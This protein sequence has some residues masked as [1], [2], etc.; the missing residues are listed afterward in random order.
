MITFEEFVKKG[1]EMCPDLWRAFYPRVYEHTGGYGS[2]KLPAIT[3][4]STVLSPM[5]SHGNKAVYMQACMLQKQD[6]PTYFIT[7]DLLFALAQTDLPDDYDLN[8]FS[9]RW[10]AVLFMLPRD[11]NKDKAGDDYPYLLLS[12]QKDAEQFQLKLPSGRHCPSVTVVKG[13]I[14]VSTSS[15]VNKDGL[16][17]GSYNYTVIP[18]I[19]NLLGEALKADESDNNRKDREDWERRQKERPLTEKEVDVF[20]TM[21]MSELEHDFS[22]ACLKL[23][24]KI[25]LFMDS[26]KDLVEMGTPKKIFHGRDQRTDIWWPNIV[27][28]SYKIRYVYDHSGEDV[29]EHEKRNVRFHWRRGHMRRQRY[30]EGRAMVKT[31]LI[32]GLF[33]GS[34]QGEPQS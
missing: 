17:I 5:E 1:A 28:K 22:K 24:L 31:I 19:Q 27:G 33:V 21:P 29:P 20:K 18:S 14:M 30:G 23:A 4:L 2:C 15:Y 3:L 11:F 7:R 25:V 34:K 9:M 6:V 8:Q 13:G 16:A 10:P 26:K 32:E 12:H